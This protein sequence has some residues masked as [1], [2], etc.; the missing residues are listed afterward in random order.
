MVRN[1]LKEFLKERKISLYRFCLD[2]AISE[3]TGRAIVND[4]FAVPSKA[5]L[6]KICDRYKVQPGRLLFW[7][8]QS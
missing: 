8:D 4:P 3:N 1:T 2:V 5:V 6:N 7:E